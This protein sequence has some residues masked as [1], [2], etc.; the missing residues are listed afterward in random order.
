MHTEMWEHPATRANVATLRARG[1]SS[2]TPPS[3]GS[4]APTPAPAG[5]PTRPDLRRRAVLRRGA[6]GESDLAG[7]HVVVSAG[8]TREPLDPVRFLGN[9]SSGQQGYALARTAVA[10]GA[11]VTLVSANVELPDPA[12]A[13]SSGSGPP[14]SCA[15]PS[16]RPPP[17][18]TPWSWP[19]RC[20]LPAGPGHRPAKIKKADAVPRP[21]RPGHQP[22]RSSPNSAPQ[23]G[24]AGQI[25]VGFAAETG[26]ARARCSTTAAPS[27]SAQAVPTCL[28]STTWA[29]TGSSAPTTRSPSW[30][31]TAAPSVRRTPQ[32]RC[33]GCDM[34][35]GRLAPGAAGQAGWDA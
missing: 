14:R 7:R 2:S 12:G 6:A 8:G 5:C 24:R 23:T 20:R 22:R 13:E 31:P 1:V 26:D 30:A 35:R 32:R 11:R 28:W 29:R 10:R 27:S 19:P 34:G 18:P 33:G 17:T 16:S 9:R 4:P 15:S 21:H 25:I 3:A